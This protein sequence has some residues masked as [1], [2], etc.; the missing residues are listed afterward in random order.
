MTTTQKEIAKKYL[1][2]QF[3]N[4]EWQNSV[5]KAITDF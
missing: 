4:E 3:T 1:K 5:K 2:E